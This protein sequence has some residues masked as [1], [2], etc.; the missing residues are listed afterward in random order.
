M[1]VP[2]KLSL[3]LNASLIGVLS[4]LLSLNQAQQK[5]PAVSIVIETTAAHLP[6]SR[7]V[8][9]MKAEQTAPSEGFLW[10]RLESRDYSAYIRNLQRIDCPAP[11]LR[12]IVTADVHAH[13]DVRSRQLEQ[14]LAG[15]QS[16]SWSVQLQSLSEQQS[17]QAE[18][19][20]LPRAEATEIASLLGD[21]LMAE[22]I[23]TAAPD[24]SAAANQNQTGPANELPQMPL[25]FQ[26]VDFSV[27]H[28]NEEQL[29]AVSELRQ[30]FLDEIGGPGQNP[31]DPT[32]LER[33]QKSQPAV[34]DQ[35]RGLL[36][37]GTFQD[38]QLAAQN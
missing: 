18:L 24:P 37:T 28:L 19:Q 7:I 5:N 17:V 15:L 26:T 16:G 9:P 34:D 1:S 13:Y 35:L 10:S 14:K 36:G 27:L 30:N 6:A 12:A 38:L 29:Q 11:T 4:W 22:G 21:N 2:L 25:V 32:Y 33:W 8:Q 20:Q 3:F 31:N 23:T